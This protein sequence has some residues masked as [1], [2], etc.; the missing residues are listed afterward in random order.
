MIFS[1]MDRYLPEGI[2]LHDQTQ[3]Q[4]LAREGSLSGDIATIDMSSASDTITRTLFWELFP[5]RF[6]S[7]VYP[8]LGT[9]HTINGRKRV[10][11]MMAT[12]GNS[13]TFVLESLVFYAIDVAAHQFNQQV[14]GG[15]ATRNVDCVHPVPSVYGDDQIIWSADYE[16][17]VHF[18]E[19]LG[20]IVNESKSY[21]G[22]SPF[23]ESCGSE[24]YMGADVS[25]VYFPRRPIRGTATE[26]SVCAE[27][28]DA[29]RDSFTGEMS[30]SL[31]SLISLQHRLY[32]VCQ[33][34]SLFLAAL[35]KETKPSLSSSPA[36]SRWDDLWDYVDDA[37]VAYAPGV[38]KMV[39]AGVL[40]AN[41]SPEQQEVYM[42]TLRLLPTVV[43]TNPSGEEIPS[44]VRR[45][46]DVYKYQEFLRNGPRYADQL[47]RDLGVS[48]R[49][50]RLEE[51]Y[52]TPTVRWRW[53]EASE[54]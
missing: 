19:A 10:M 28:T 48:E 1:I 22:D 39:E 13:L 43:Y 49:P 21:T 38:R 29:R 34:A 6:A 40:P 7:L 27:L 5:L 26:K 3:N 33:E 52:F 42:R 31:S 20:F 53:I 4:E 41:L 32:D 16:V 15:I 50:L 8:Y 30:T 25:S 12:S 37:R 54:A 35:A 23:R 2:Q 11:Q 51:V 45:L 24:W 17:T 18:L 46:Y 9:H 44:L 14:C 47:M 36:G